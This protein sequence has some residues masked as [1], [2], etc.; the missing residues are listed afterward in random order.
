MSKGSAGNKTPL[1]TLTELLTNGGNL[2][3]GETCSVGV[4][5]QGNKN[6]NPYKHSNII[7]PRLHQSHEYE[8]PW[9]RMT[10]GDTGKPVSVI[11]VL[12]PPRNLL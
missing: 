9:P 11:E 8:Y 7:T 4:W 3:Y 10:S 2:G 1:E 12:Q 5:A 6:T